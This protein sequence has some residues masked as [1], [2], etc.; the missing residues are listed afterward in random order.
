MA[1]RAQIELNKE[2]AKFIELG[3]GKFYTF[4]TYVKL[5]IAERLKKDHIEMAK[6]GE[7]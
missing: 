5:A 4:T 3:L 7:I 6:D 1:I 2:R